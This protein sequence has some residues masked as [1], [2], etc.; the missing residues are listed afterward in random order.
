MHNLKAISLALLVGSLPQKSRADD[1]GLWIGAAALGLGAAAC[2]TYAYGKHQTNSRWQT[3]N[4]ARDLVE[5]M[6]ALAEIDS[7]VSTIHP[8]SARTQHIL[9]QNITYRIDQLE[10][11]LQEARSTVAELQTVAQNADLPEQRAQALEA[12]SVIN[13]LKPSLE[14]LLGI[15]H[16]DARYG[17]FKEIV[18][19][20]IV[21]V[22]AEGY[23]ESRYEIVQSARMNHAQELFPIHAAGKALRSK[24]GC[25]EQSIAQFESVASNSPQ[26]SAYLQVISDARELNGIL[27][28]AYALLVSTPDYR[29][30]E[31]RMVMHE[32][33]M[34]LVHAERSKAKAFED[35]A[36][37]YREQTRA[38]ERLTDSNTRLARAREDARMMMQMLIP[39][40]HHLQ[41]RLDLL[42]Q[43]ISCSHCTGHHYCSR[44]CEAQRLADEI[45]RLVVD[46]ERLQRYAW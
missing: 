41:C 10:R 14:R 7:H 13:S 17:T 27:R 43:S 36:A 20:A 37:A 28:Q 23:S 44:H 22:R 9:S 11:A 5:R 29:D 38:Y 8:P 16:T 46:F 35:Q 39:Q 1:V 2:G 34:A 32:G 4:A 12:I 3:I 24:I 31:P 15:L 30:E 42:N 18:N 19:N 21:T 25:L 33:Q 6:Q 40:I 45:R 26:N